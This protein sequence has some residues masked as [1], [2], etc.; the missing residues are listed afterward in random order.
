MPR[1]GNDL[2]S[3]ARSKIQ[4]SLPP[5]QQDNSNALPSGQSDRSKSRPM[6]RL[7]LQQLKCQRFNKS[8]MKTYNYLVYDKS[9]QRNCWSNILLHAC[10]FW[11]CWSCRHQTVQRECWRNRRCGAGW[12]R[13]LSTIAMW[14]NSRFS[15]FNRLMFLALH[16]SAHATIHVLVARAMFLEAVV[17][18]VSLFISEISSSDTRGKRTWSTAIVPVF[19]WTK[20]G[21][22][23]EEILAYCAVVF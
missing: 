1:P 18:P 11:I 10:I 7:S 3:L 19:C 20:L 16:H 23:T 12:C 14:N 6:P 22:S 4:I 5:G 13:H 15:V 9:T 8:A 2:W 17:L 21:F